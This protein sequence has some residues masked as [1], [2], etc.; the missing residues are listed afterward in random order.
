MR[1][2]NYTGEERFSLELVSISRYGREVFWE[3]LGFVELLVDYYS[4]NKFR[5]RD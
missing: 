4:V 1:I 2:R 5:E 3:Y